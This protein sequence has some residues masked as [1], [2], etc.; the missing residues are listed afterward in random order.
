[1][2]SLSTVLMLMAATA[3]SALPGGGGGGS[4]SQCTTAQ[5][6][7]CCTGL[8]LDILNIDVLPGLCLREC[9]WKLRSSKF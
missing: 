5:A 7:K 1:M 6:N 4:P 3:V 9:P 8:S 2:H